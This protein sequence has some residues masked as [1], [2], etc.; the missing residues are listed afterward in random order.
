MLDWI[1]LALLCSIPLS[2][3]PLR[4]RVAA[5]LGD[6]HCLVPVWKAAG[7]RSRIFLETLKHSLTA[8]SSWPTRWV[9]LWATTSRWSRAIACM[10]SCSQEWAVA[11]PTSGE[12]AELNWT[13]VFWAFSLSEYGNKSCS[14]LACKPFSQCCSPH[15][16]CHGPW[17]ARQD[18]HQKQQRWRVSCEPRVFLRLYGNVWSWLPAPPHATAFSTVCGAC[19][20]RCHS[21]RFQETMN[22]LIIQCLCLQQNDLGTEQCKVRA[23]WCYSTEGQTKAT[24]APG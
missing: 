19:G 17:G 18:S 1:L 22:L 20:V 5:A 11:L 2:P 3:S 7:G 12:Q 24:S 16:Q 21:A 15:R 6:A 9:P 14:Y 8:H 13:T 10:S 4:L 23:R